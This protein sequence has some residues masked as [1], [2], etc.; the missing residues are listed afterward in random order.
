MMELECLAYSVGHADDG[1]CLLARMGPHRILL[2]CGLKDISS[3]TSNESQSMPADFAICTH[4]HS[5]HA[6]GFLALHRAFPQLPVYASS[7]TAKLLPLNWPD[8]PVTEVPRFCE[9]VPWN[10]TVEL[11][12][13]LTLQIYPAGHLPGAAC[14]SIAYATPNRTYKL[15]YTGDVF[16]S[17]CRLVE[18]MPLGELRGLKPDIL[19][20]E[21]SYGTARY[22]H[23]RQLENQLAERV[24]REIISGRSVMLPTPILGLGQELLMLLRSHHYFTGRDLDIWVDGGI[25]KGCDLYL[26]L[27]SEFP[28]SV[29]NFAR[30]QPLFWDDRVRPRVRRLSAGEGFGTKPC[31]AIVDREKL[32]SY[33][34]DRQTDWVLFLPEKPGTRPTALNFNESNFNSIQTYLLTNHCDG[35]GTTQLI[36]NLRPQ[37]II[38]MHGNP[39]YIADLTNLEELR[40][41]YQL[42]SPAK[43]SLVELP[44]GETFFQP[45]ISESS[46]EGEL[47][48]YNTEI[49]ISLPK[50]IAADPRWSNFSDTGIVEARWQGEEL[51]LR[52][53]SQREILSQG[54]DRL[55]PADLECCGNCLY[56]RGQRCWNQ[57]SALFGFKVTPEGY[58]PAFEG[59]R[60]PQDLELDEDESD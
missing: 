5:D 21:S 4:A 41:R 46:Y 59:I 42:H 58:C 30:H 2:D 6:R 35:S 25:A 26:E 34:S 49:A 23:R 44:I 22:P 33:V 17:N 53:I 18:G 40:N 12:K 55:L 24:Y 37:H 60:F 38:F 28:A 11:A 50:E 19:I 29:Q 45:P 52:G 54:S 10:S 20:V 3:L 43:G 48:D 27:L 14:I 47:A 13:G 15:F 8:L 39:T 7:A 32:E 51:V 57:V 9:A 56:Y 1:I 36:H 31:I 16:L